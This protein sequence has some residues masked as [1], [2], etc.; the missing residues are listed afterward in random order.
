M[1]W[2]SGLVNASSFDSFT[3]HFHSIFHFH[4]APSYRCIC[5]NVISKSLDSNDRIERE[6]IVSDTM[7]SLAN[8]E[9]ENGFC[10]YTFVAAQR[11]ANVQIQ[12][13]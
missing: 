5:S 13:I 11:I 7:E 4:K 3:K 2:C 8:G 12:L 6:K 1:N 9:I 10:C